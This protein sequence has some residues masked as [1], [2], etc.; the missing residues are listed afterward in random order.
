MEQRDP[1][2]LS[3]RRDGTDAAFCSSGLE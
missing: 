3:V 1:A 2:S